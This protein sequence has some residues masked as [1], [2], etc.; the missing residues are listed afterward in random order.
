MDNVLTR[1]YFVHPISAHYSSTSST[2]VKTNHR[3]TIVICNVIQ[4]Q[5]IYIYHSINTVFDSY[6]QP[7]ALAAF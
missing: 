5:S 4:Y 3:N 2:H 1:I 6:M 7:Y